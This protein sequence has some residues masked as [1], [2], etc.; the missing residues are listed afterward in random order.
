MGIGLSVGATTSPSHALDTEVNATSAAQSYALGSP[1]GNV[2]IKR[3]RFMQTLGLGLYHLE[4]GEPV[5]G[6]PE[7]SVKIRLRLDAAAGITSA[8]TTFAATS[9]SF[10]PGLA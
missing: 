6:G 1:W 8:E 4:G 2:E 7:L 5:P 9:A 3:R 10:V